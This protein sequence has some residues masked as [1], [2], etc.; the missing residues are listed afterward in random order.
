MQ[1]KAEMERKARKEKENIDVDTS[2]M[3]Y[4]RLKEDDDENADNFDNLKMLE[5]LMNKDIQE[6]ENPFALFEE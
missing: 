1:K 4:K 3:K 6:I 5:L 2:F